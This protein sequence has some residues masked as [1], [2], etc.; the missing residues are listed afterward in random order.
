[1]DQW[2]FVSAGDGRVMRLLHGNREVLVVD[3][4]RLQLVD[5]VGI[6]RGLTRVIGEG[7]WPSWEDEQYILATLN[8]AEA[9]GKKE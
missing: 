3:R 8:A 1:M 9:A 2:R 4:T 5:D 7:A 6:P